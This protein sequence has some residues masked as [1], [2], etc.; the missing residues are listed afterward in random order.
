MTPSFST[1][2]TCMFTALAANLTL[3]APGGT[4]NGGR[5][6]FRFKDNGVA[7]TLTWNAIYRGIEALPTT[8][9]AGKWMYIEAVYNS[10][11]SRWDVIYV[12]IEP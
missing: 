5:I 10:A 7:R 8:T 4:T 2:L 12:K 6:L 1:A 9:T 3:N 11:D